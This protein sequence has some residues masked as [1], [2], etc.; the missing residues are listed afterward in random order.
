METF[1]KEERHLG[2]FRTIS[3]SSAVYATNLDGNHP[4]KTVALLVSQ[5]YDLSDFTNTVVQFDMAFDL[6]ED[7]DYI[8]FEYSIDAGDTWKILGTS[9]DE[10]WFN[11]ARFADDQ[12]AAN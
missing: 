7:W 5:C 3:D 11:N 10:N 8:T 6:E 1:G 12:V 2:H 4:D 9:E